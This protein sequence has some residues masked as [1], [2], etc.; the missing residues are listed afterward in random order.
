MAR[1]SAPEAHFWEPKFGEDIIYDYY[2]HGNLLKKMIDKRM[3]EIGLHTSRS[4]HRE[5]I[6]DRAAEKVKQMKLNTLE[7]SILVR[8]TN[9]RQNGGVSVVNE[10][11][12]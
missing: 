5:I 7:V 12:V 6:V 1:L 2:Q 11:C 4:K 8:S 10:N 3:K 9:Y